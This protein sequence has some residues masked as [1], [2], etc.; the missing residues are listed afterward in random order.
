M[1]KRKGKAYL[2]YI[3]SNACKYI[4]FQDAFHKDLL[5][6]RLIRH[7]GIDGQFMILRIYMD[8]FN[9]NCPIG[10]SSSKHK[11]LGVYLRW[12]IAQSYTS[13]VI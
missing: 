12:V 4:F 13:Q 3:K 11:I 5:N 6:G 10:S 9:V 8:E 7:M 1:K 2:F